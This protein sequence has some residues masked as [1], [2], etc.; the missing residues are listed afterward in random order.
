MFN[1]LNNVVHSPWPPSPT[2]PS[3]YT[4]PAVSPL[5]RKNTEWHPMRRPCGSAA[6][7]PPSTHSVHGTGP[8]WSATTSPP[9]CTPSENEPTEWICFTRAFSLTYDRW[10]CCKGRPFSNSTKQS[11]NIRRKAATRS[12]VSP[13]HTCSCLW[14]MHDVSHGA[15]GAS[16]P[17]PLSSSNWLFSLLT[18][19]LTGTGS[20]R[21]FSLWTFFQLTQTKH[22]STQAR[23]QS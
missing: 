5:P 18:L 7:G 23:T 16:T 11:T 1:V 10:Q 14:F 15:G 4:P 19:H 21:A 3:V 9:W 13:R 12:R 17:V 20:P 2:A 8:G 6:G 22:K